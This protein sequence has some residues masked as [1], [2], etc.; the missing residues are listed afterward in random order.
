[1]ALPRLQ[2]TLHGAELPGNLDHSMVEVNE[3]KN[4]PSYAQLRRIEVRGVLN[5]DRTALAAA[6]AMQ[7]ED[8]T[9]ENASLREK[10]RKMKDALANSKLET[11]DMSEQFGELAKSWKEMMRQMKSDHDE[12]RNEYEI[13]IEALEKA[14]ERLMME[15]AE[16]KRVIAN[17]ERL[18]TEL[19][20]ANDKLIRDNE[21]TKKIVADLREKHLQSEEERVKLLVGQIAFKLESLVSKYVF[22]GTDR[23]S[24]RARYNLQLKT[25][26]GKIEKMRD[27]EGVKEQATARLSDLDKEMFESWFLDMVDDLTQSRLYLAHPELGS[28]Q[29][30]E[31]AINDYCEDGE[32][33]EDKL[34]ALKHLQ[35]MYG[36]LKLPFGQ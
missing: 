4:R 24:K 15:N 32:E 30:M 18:Q 29:E 10:V 11:A 27:E 31:N 17:F 2:A 5:R 9:D 23:A 21:E 14:N 34:K 35:T 3:E 22:P 28:Y 20:E 19:K 26:Q 16:M 6:L 7:N 33:R 36:K 12:S 1:M 8:L 25:L 13:R